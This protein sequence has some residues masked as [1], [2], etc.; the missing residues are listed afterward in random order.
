M[1]EYTT[2]I[3]RL[4]ELWDQ[5]RSQHMTRPY[6][7][8]LEELVTLMTKRVLMPIEGQYEQP[9]IAPNRMR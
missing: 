8:V 2:L 7:S 5:L 3:A 4:D 1:D 9:R 6:L